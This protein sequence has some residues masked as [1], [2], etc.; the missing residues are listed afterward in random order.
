MAGEEAVLWR[1]DIPSL[2]LPVLA[3][4]HDAEEVVDVPLTDREKRCL[5]VPIGDL[6]DNKPKLLKARS[7]P[8]RS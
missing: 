2:A 3:L 5:A 4:I 6:H 7:T 1:T 8:S